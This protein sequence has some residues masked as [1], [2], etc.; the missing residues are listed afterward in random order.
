MYLKDVDE[1]EYFDTGSMKGIKIETGNMGTKVIVMD[2]D[3]DE[4][5]LNY[6][7]GIHLLANT[8]EVLK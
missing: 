8:T 6:Y 1:G 3:I 2:A 5:D 4:E 7:L